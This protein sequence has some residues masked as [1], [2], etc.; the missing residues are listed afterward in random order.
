MMMIEDGTNVKID[1][2]LLN[3][4]NPVCEM[5]AS[6]VSRSVVFQNRQ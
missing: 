3:A 4:G 6:S 1:T 5:T 2:D